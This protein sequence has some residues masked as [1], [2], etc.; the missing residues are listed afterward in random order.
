MIKTR[1]L[2][3]GIRVIMEEMPG[4]QSIAIGIWMRTGAIDE[5]A[6]NAGISHFVEHMM[7]KGTENRTAKEIAADIDRIGGQINAFTGKEATCYYVKSVSDNYK[8]AA[9]VLVDMVENSLFDKKEMDR[10]RKVICEEIKMTKDSPD[11]LAHDTLISQVFKGEALGNS[12]IGTPSSL[13]GITH[14]VI[15]E[16]VREQYVRDSLVISAAGNFDCDDLCDYFSDKFSSLKQSKAPLE[17][18]HSEY[19]KTCRSLKKD[20]QQSHLCLGKP[21]VTLKNENSYVLQILNN[22]LGG[23]MSSRLFQNIREEKGLAYSVFSSMGTFGNGGY[24]EIYAGVSHDKIR[25]AVEGI[26]EELDKLAAE[27]VTQDE[28]DS[29]REQMKSGYVFSQEST[30]TRMVLNGKNY[31]LIDKVFT[32][33]EVIKGYDDVTIEKIEEVKNMICNFDDYSA[34]A[35]SN[36]KVDLRSIMG[37]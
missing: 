28:L 19:E 4:V 5:S 23:S 26:K 11:D 18:K 12:I 32:P 14:N 30:S 22:I 20:I 33:E 15:T 9:D 24:F 29:S 35:V 34:V 7:F 25:A 6:K 37:K 21:G 17:L 8:K 13:K 2:S 10:E 3:N 36:R 16:Y 27:P 1:K 31:I